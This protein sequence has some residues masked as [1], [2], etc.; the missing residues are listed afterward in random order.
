MERV[1]PP[2]PEGD[3]RFKA[4][5]SYHK[6]YEWDI[7]GRKL[8]AVHY[9]TGIGSNLWQQAK[10]VFLFD[11]YFLP[12]RNGIATVQ[13]YRGHRADEGALGSMTTLNSKSDDVQI[14]LDGHRLRWT[15]QLALRGNGRNYDESGLCGVQRLA[16]ISNDLE[17][18][19]CYTLIAYSP[20]QN[21]KIVQGETKGTWAGKVIKVLSDYQGPELNSRQLSAVIKKTWGAI[22][23]RV[24]TTEFHRSLTAIGW[25][26]VPGKGKR[27][28]VFKRTT[29][30]AA[31]AA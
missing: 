25:Q 30:Q 21:I 10:V 7:G 2:R 14:F 28:S 27:M 18:F 12:R 29:P 26:Y 11:D 23:T 17:D 6:D 16:V 24:L 22:S 9:G 1:A 4:P 31:I 13:G 5:D 8:C 15:K 3:T 20:E 19:P